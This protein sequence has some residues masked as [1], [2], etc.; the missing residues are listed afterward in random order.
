MSDHALKLKEFLTRQLEESV[1]KIKKLKRKRNITKC[2]YYSTT[3]SSIVISAVL[4]ATATAVAIPPVAIVVLSTASG[5]LTT[6]SSRFNFQA[7]TS[8]L[9]TEIEKCNK[10]SRSL[11][12]VV[13]TNGDLTSDACKQI[14]S[15][16]N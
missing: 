10:L 7:K 13:S 14:L 5:I 3:V 1:S 8:K 16:Y 9:N 2:L 6:I 12:Y 15:E 4:A 11:D